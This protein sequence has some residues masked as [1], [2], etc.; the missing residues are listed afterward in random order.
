MAE[1]PYDVTFITPLIMLL[2]ETMAVTLAYRKQ[3]AP[4]SEGNSSM[5]EVNAYPSHAGEEQHT[6]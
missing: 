5:L 3:R 4:P 2:L 6:R 1:H